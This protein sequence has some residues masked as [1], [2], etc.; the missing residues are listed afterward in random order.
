MIKKY[1]YELKTISSVIL[2]PR[3]Q[4][5]FYHS[6]DSENDKTQIIYPFYQYGTYEAY[7]PKKAQYYIPGSSIKGAISSDRLMVDDILIKAED[8]SLE[9]IY[10]VQHISGMD[11]SAGN[12]KAMK[13]EAFFPSVKVE[14][15]KAGK[16][17]TGDIYCDS[18]PADILL[19]AQTRTEEKLKKYQDFIDR[20]YGVGDLGKGNVEAE[21]SC[22][23]IL[24]KVGGNL[25]DIMSKDKD[26]D[27]RMF[28][29]ILGGFKGKILSGAFEHEGGIY[30]DKTTE[31]PHGLVTLTLVGNENE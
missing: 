22:M 31:L 28:L 7:D 17:Y 25:R 24:R 18:L 30:I 14:K 2:S 23:D 8:L 11:G 21:Q 3:S 1:T 9:N 19:N 15:L 16:C 4:N 29:L 10:K 5:S 12:K 26:H 6:A 20:V 13:L 27:E